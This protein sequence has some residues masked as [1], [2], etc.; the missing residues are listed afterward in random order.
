MYSRADNELIGPAE[1]GRFIQSA[2]MHGHDLF[3][4]LPLDVVH[5]QKFL[6][7]EREVIGDPRQVGVAQR[8]QDFCFTL[9]LRTTLLNDVLVGFRAITQ[10]LERNAAVE[11]QVLGIIYRAHGAL[12]HQQDQAITIGED[13]IRVQHGVV[14]YSRKI[15]G[16]LGRGSIGQALP[17]SVSISPAQDTRGRSDGCALIVGTVLV[18]L[19]SLRRPPLRRQPI[20]L[21]LQFGHLLQQRL[22]VAVCRQPS[23]R[24]IML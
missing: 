5:D 23:V 21:L 17:T 15:I 2:G 13:L 6:I 20:N 14:G 19:N 24:Q 10:P 8:R 18:L 12:S 3:E 7:A 4:G 22:K 16:S 1:D 9:E 11:H